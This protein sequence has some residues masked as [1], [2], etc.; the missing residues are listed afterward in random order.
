MRSASGKHLQLLDPLHRSGRWIPWFPRAAWHHFARPLKR[1]MC[2]WP[3]RQNHEGGFEIL[4]RCSKGVI[5]TALHFVE[6]P[7]RAILRCSHTFQ[8][9]FLIA[10]ERR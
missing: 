5:F 2:N 6:R 9:S 4:P 7:G 3:C 8:Q 1:W 10:I